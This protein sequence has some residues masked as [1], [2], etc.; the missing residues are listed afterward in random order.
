MALGACW[1]VLEE[2][3]CSE[4]GDYRTTDKILYRG[5]RAGSYARAAVKCGRVSSGFGRETV[6]DTACISDFPN[7]QESQQ[8]SSLILTPPGVL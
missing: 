4:Q 3:L 8:F 2:F 1:D 7:S 5:L 6:Q